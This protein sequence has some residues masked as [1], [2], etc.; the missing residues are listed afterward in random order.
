MDDRQEVLSEF[1]FGS[2]IVTLENDERCSRSIDD[3]S[4]ELRAKSR[5]AVFVGNHNL[6]DAAFLDVD[7]KPRER[8]AFV[9]EAGADVLVDFV[10]RVERLELLVL[11]FEVVFLFPRRDATVDCS[12]FFCRLRFRVGFELSEGL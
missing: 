1:L 6:L 8:F 4:D 11:P 7:Q 9:L 5:Q 2:D 12:L 3:P 10:V